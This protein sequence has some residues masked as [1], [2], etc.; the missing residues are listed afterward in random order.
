MSAPGSAPAWPPRSGYSRKK[1]SLR[2]GSEAIKAVE[3]PLRWV[4]VP[5]KSKAFAGA[6]FYLIVPVARTTGSL[7]ATPHSRRGPEGPWLRCSRVWLRPAG[8]FHRLFKPRSG[9]AGEYRRPIFGNSLAEKLFDPRGPRNAL[10]CGEKS[11][12][13]GVF[14]RHMSVKKQFHWAKRLR[15]R[16]LFGFSVSFDTPGGGC[17]R[18]R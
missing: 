1:A 3:K 12:G 4:L 5:R 10:H 6:P 11:A 14:S 17:R 9:P 2:T 15:K 13:Y 18:R 8:R 7:H 16:S